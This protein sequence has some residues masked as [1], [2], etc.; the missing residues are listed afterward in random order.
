MVN[1]TVCIITLYHILSPRPICSSFTFYPIYICNHTPG[2][3]SALSLVSIKATLRPLQASAVSH[4]AVS[5]ATLY[6]DL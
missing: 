5:P 1:D 4:V 2:M 3:K 6:P